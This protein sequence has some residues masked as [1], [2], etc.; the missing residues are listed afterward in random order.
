AAWDEPRK[1]PRDIYATLAQLPTQDLVIG[2][3]AGVQAGRVVEA[4]YTRPYQLHGAI[5]PSCAV[6]RYENGALTIW[7]HAQGMYP[8][9]AAVAELLGLP[10]ERVRCIHMEGAGC[11]GHNGADDVA[12]DAALI[13]K[14]LP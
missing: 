6:A 10:T 7:S 5:G 3:G 1:L 12:A 9:R 8:L 4:A 14:A 13:A 11:Y 2:D